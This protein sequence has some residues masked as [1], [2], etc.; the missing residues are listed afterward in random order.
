AAGDA[1]P[2]AVLVL[3]RRAG[4]LDG[5]RT[6]SAFLYGVAVRVAQKARVREARRRARERE[7]I[8]VPTPD[9]TPDADWRDVRTVIDEELDRLA[10]RYR[11]PIVLCCL[12]GR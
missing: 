12:E 2:A 6:A 8:R 11:D 5:V 1:S 4:S 9:P 3:A 10:A 7:A